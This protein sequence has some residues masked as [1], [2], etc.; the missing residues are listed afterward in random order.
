[1]RAIGLRIHEKKKDKKIPGGIYQGELLQYHVMKTQ[2]KKK[3][4]KGMFN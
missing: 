1:M 4:Q 3:V 2:F